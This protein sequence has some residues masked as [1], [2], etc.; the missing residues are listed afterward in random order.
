MDNRTSP[1]RSAQLTVLSVETLEQYPIARDERL[2]ELGFIKWVPSRWLNS[3]GHLKCSYEVQGMARALFDISTA[4]SPIGTLPDD[5]EVLAKLLRVDPGHWQS[6]RALGN[7]GPMRN[8]RH[9]LC[10][11]ETRLMHSVVTETLIDVLHRREQRELSKEAQATAKRMERLAS[12]L[13]QLGVDQAVTSDGVL[14]TRMDDWLR[15][16]CRGNRTQ[17]AYARA[18][19]HAAAQGWLELPRR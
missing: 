10:G 17:A 4:Q 14:M 8:W 15:D 16:N 3:S 5:D 2:P 13:H 19:T 1:A 9:C 6:M 12:G 18:L 7:R 11:D